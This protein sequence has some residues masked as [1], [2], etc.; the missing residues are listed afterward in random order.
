MAHPRL[1]RVASHASAIEWVQVAAAVMLSCSTWVGA[2]DPDLFA[3][4]YQPRE[5]EPPYFH[6][7]EN[8]TASLVCHGDSV[9][10]GASCSA[11]TRDFRTAGRYCFAGR[12]SHRLRSGAAVG[13]VEV[14]RTRLDPRVVRAAGLSLYVSGAGVAP[15]VA[16]PVFCVPILPRWAVATTAPRHNHPSK[17]RRRATGSSPLGAGWPDLVAT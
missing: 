6:G 3:G 4:G 11:P 16:G 9:C 7:R 1:P 17:R 13:S 2:R 12:I 8:A 14:S 10:H 15:R 5:L